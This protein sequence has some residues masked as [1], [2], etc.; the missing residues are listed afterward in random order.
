MILARKRLVLE[1]LHFL[2]IGKTG[3]SAIK[4]MIAGKTG[5][6]I[7]KIPFEAQSSSP[8][9]E[10][11]FH[12][13]STRLDD[14][15]VG[16]KVFFPIRDVYTRYCSAFYSRKRK[17]RPLFNIQWNEVEE[18]CFDTFHTPEELVNGLKSK[19]S[20]I[21][22]IAESAFISIKHIS[23]KLSYWLVDTEY[24]KDRSKDILYILEQESLATDFKILCDELSLKLNNTLPEEENAIHR[25]IERNY[26]LSSDSIDFLNSF[27]HDDFP[28]IDICRKIKATKLINS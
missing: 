4:L 28:L 2:H 27:Y 20:E 25:N 6:S 21:A 17:G 3:G 24:L 7:V 11:I 10:I 13:H 8:S 1:K 19:D 26:I 16:E 9:H 12:A 18:K 15:P 23:R 14:I 5:K 22:Q